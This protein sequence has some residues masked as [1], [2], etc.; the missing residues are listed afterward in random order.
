[1]EGIYA[2]KNRKTGKVVG[3]T[4][5]DTKDQAKV[6]RNKFNKREHKDWEEQTQKG[7]ATYCVV[8]SASHPKVGK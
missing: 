2:I 1:M 5:Y 4:T 7:S 6:D 8:R 3:Q